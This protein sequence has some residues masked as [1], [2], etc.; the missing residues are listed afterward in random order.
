MHALSLIS[1][2]ECT[3]DHGG[4]TL[5]QR[6]EPSR[7]REA[8]GRMIRSPWN[9]NGRARVITS[10]CGDRGWVTSRVVYTVAGVSRPLTAQANSQLL[11]PYQA[12]PR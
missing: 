7:S 9:F 11:G 1:S 8:F 10:S 3:A 5:D 2:I 4:S 6:L 12:G